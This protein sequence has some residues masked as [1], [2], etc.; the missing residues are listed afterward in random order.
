MQRQKIQVP[1]SYASLRFSAVFSVSHYRF[2]F[3]V[4]VEVSVFITWITSLQF[5]TELKTIT[6]SIPDSI[7]SEKSSE[8]DGRVD[9]SSEQ[10]HVQVLA[11]QYLPR[12]LLLVP[13][14]RRYFQSRTESEF[15]VAAQSRRFECG[16][17]LTKT[18]WHRMRTNVYPQ[19]W[20]TMEDRHERDVKRCLRQVVLVPEALSTKPWH[21]EYLLSRWFRRSLLWFSWII[22]PNR[23]LRDINLLQSFIVVGVPMRSMNIS[24]SSPPSRTTNK[25]ET[26]FGS[27]S[28]H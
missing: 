4:M 11:Q 23:D 19:L 10:S 18:L 9:Y 13:S 28:K 8:T 7:A 14:F 22:R 12:S 24:N 20:E 17:T 15:V 21:V 5:F 16:G 2:L 27:W 3:E 25:Q 1:F 26:K 6:A